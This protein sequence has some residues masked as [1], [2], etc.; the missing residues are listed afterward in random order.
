VV[1]SRGKLLNPTLDPYNHVW[2]ASGVKGAEIRVIDQAGGVVAIPNPYGVTVAIRAIAMSLEGSRL[3][4]LH[5][6]YNGTTV[7]IFPVVRDKTGK[8]VGIAPRFPLPQ[9]GNSTQAISWVDRVTLAGLAKDKAGLQ[10][11]IT[12]MVGG[13]SVVGRTTINGKSVASTV[14]GSHFYLDSNGELFSSKSFG[15]DKSADEVLAMRM[16]GQ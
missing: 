3:A 4:I 8:V 1:D 6:Y 2:T 13:D 9:F 11:M 14:G 7:D 12:T 5:D 15:W 10:S 16:A